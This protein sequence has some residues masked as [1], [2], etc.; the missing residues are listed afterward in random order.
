MSVIDRQIKRQT[1]L[2]MNLLENM[3]K[4]SS[5]KAVTFQTFLWGILLGPLEIHIL[6]VT[7]QVQLSRT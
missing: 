6:N 2:V 7:M 1:D 4:N 3:H 5:F